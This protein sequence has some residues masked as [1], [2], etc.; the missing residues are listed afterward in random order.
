MLRRFLQRQASD[1]LQRFGPWAI[2]AGGSEGIG[3]AF[4]EELAARGFDLV[5]VAERAEPLEGFA[6][7]L[8]SRSSRRVR[9]LVLDLGELDAHAQLRAEVETLDVGLGVYNAAFSEVKPFNEQSLQAKLRTLDV[10]ARGALMFCDWVAPRLT[11]RGR[12]GLLLMSSLAALQG[13]PRV[14]SYA[15]TKAFDLVLAEALWHELKPAG[16]SVLAACAGAT[17][18][19]GYTKTQPKHAGLLSP[20][21]MEPEEVA[22][23]AL[24]ALGSGPSHVIGR[25]NR[26]VASLLARVLGRR[27]AVE[28]LGRSM[29]DQ[30]R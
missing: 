4:A 6:R 12:G 25:S 7:D 2:V 15:A 28:T 20:P 3:A 8:A 21:L 11:A 10:N 27:R 9:P 19:P 17:R 23:E 1:Y 13:T 18:T 26:L 24:D 5:L 14:A 30:Y 29:D 16:V 22:R